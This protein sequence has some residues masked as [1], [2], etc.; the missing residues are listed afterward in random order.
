MT[1]DDLPEPPDDSIVG[2]PARRP[3][4]VRRTAHINMVWPGGFGTPLQLRGHARDLVTRTDGSADIAAEAEVVVDVG[5][6]RTIEAISSVPS[7]QGIEDLVG[8]RGGERFRSAV[9]AALPGEREAA[10]PLY[11][12][13]DDI[14]GATLIAGFAWSQTRQIMLPAEGPGSVRLLSRDGR[15]ICSGLR[16]GGYHE[17]SRQQGNPLPHFLRRPGDLSDPYDPMAWHDIEPAPDVCMRRRRRVD[18]WPTGSTITVDAHFRDSLWD[19]HHDELAVHEYTL[20]ATI[21]T[22]S[23]VLQSIVAVP[24][25]LPFPECPWAAPHAS[26]LVGMPVGGFRTS[27]QDS[28]TELQCC[29][30]LTDMVRCLAEVPVLAGALLPSGRA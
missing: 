24:R 5:D 12:L 29:T 15:T 16:P 3:G 14:A 28:L 7:H 18:A 1:I 9:D 19:V 30:H 21:D 4:S 20:Q 17:L 10:T 25:V 11:F 22:D 13:L 26:M 23:T 2:T 6:R 27:V 8:A